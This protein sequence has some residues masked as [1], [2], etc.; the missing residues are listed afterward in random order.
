MNFI[1]Q[2]YDPWNFSM[3]TSSFCL[4][5]SWQYFDGDGQEEPL[6]GDGR[7]GWSYQSVGHLRVLRTGHGRCHNHRST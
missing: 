3:M 1:S 4:L 6:H 5:Y 7:R 2:D